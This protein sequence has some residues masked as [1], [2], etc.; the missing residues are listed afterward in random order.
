MGVQNST[1]SGLPQ[2]PPDSAK[3]RKVLLV[4]NTYQQAGGED[5]VFAAEG[6]LLEE[7]G[8]EVRRYQLH[9]DAVGEKG[10]L[11]LAMAAFWNRQSHRELQDLLSEFQP[12]IVH[13]HNTLP[14][15]SPAVYY[16]AQKAG[17]AVVQTLHNFRLF[18]P[19]ALLFRNGQPCED[20]LGKPLAWRGV[21]HACYRDSRA[22]TAVSAASTG[23]HRALGTYG[24]KIDRYIALTEFGAEKARQGGLPPE[25]VC[26]KPNF[27]SEDPGVGEGKGGYALFVGRLS[28]EKGI[29]VLLKAFAQNPGIP[30]KIAGSGPEENAVR[31]AADASDYITYL[32]KQPREAVLDLM[33]DAAF[34][35]FPSVWY[36][37]FGLVAAEAFACGTPVIASNLGAPGE[38]VTHQQTGLH[39][40][41]GDATDLARQIHWL[42]QHAKDLARMRHNARREY[43]EKYTAERNYELLMDVYREAR[44]AKVR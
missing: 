38:I 10:K 11:G 44:A 22:A 33:R 37:T 25:K 24:R 20:C 8:H 30:L 41:P 31:K 42:C 36:E 4:H 5:Q 13:V 34:L 17:A 29:Y 27:L 43:E 6:S 19:K 16:A 7:K 18:C 32:G 3:G 40:R 2:T 9:N 23:F 21:V 28:S 1:G 12:D 26:V 15:V 14:L 35:I 39:F